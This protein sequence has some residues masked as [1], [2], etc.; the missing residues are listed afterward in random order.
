MNSHGVEYIVVGGHAVAYHGY[1]RFTGDFDL[2]VRASAENARRIIAVLRS[3]DFGDLG[4]VQSTL[5]ETGKVIQI[6]RPPNRIDLLTGISG[7]TF[8]E[9][10]ATSVGVE[11]DGLPVRMIGFERLIENKNASARPK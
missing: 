8:E 6:G 1:P 9:A 10:F 7:V 2:F 5:V 11:L 4:D 3:L